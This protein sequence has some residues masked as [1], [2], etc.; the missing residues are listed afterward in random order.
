M[1]VDGRAQGAGIN[2]IDGDAEEGETKD[3]LDRA[4][5]AHVV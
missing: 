3:L 1:R 2:G 5:H 4:M